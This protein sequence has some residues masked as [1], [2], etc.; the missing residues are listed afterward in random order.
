[1]LHTGEVEIKMPPKLP[2][3]EKTPLLLNV[4]PSFSMILPI[5]LMTLLGSSLYG[6]NTSFMYASLISGGTGC[7]LGGI[8]ALSNRL[9]QNH[10]CERRIAHMKEE[11]QRYLADRREYLMVC[12]QDNRR[13]LETLYPNA[14]TILHGDSVPLVQRHEADDDFAFA[15]LGTGEIP[16]QM[17]IKLEG[18]QEGLFENE[19]EIAAKALAEEYRMISDCPVGIDFRKTHHVAINMPKHLESTYEYILNILCQ[20]ALHVSAGAMKICIFADKQNEYQRRLTEIVK[21]VPHL[22]LNGTGRRLLGID[23]DSA[24]RT[25]VELSR[26]IEKDDVFW[27]VLVLDDGYLKDETTYQTIM[28]ENFDN[29]SV[30]LLADKDATPPIF[31]ENIEFGKY[32]GAESVSFRNAEKLL[33]DSVRSFDVV[34]GDGGYIPDKVGYLEMYGISRI[35]EIKLL[36]NWRRNSMSDRIRV[37]IGIRE[38]NMIVY[39]DISEK[40]H[41][42]HGLLAGTTGSGKSELI[43]TYVIG[44]C[45]NYSPTS[46]NFLLIDYKGGGT[47]NVI[48]AL[49]HCAGVI[50]NLSGNM[51]LRAIHAISSEVK[52][53][54]MILASHGLAHVDEYRKLEPNMQTDGPMP[55]LILIID[56][57]AELK[58]EEPEFMREI[59]SLAA[60]GRSLGIHLIL[61]TQKPAGV[62]DDKIWSNSHFKLCLKVQDKQDSM[63]MLHRGEAALLSKA[64]QCYLQ[65]GNNEYFGKFQTA[66]CKDIYIPGSTSKGVFMMDACANK[67]SCK[68][69]SDTQQGDSRTVLEE[70]ADY[71][72]QK[73]PN[74]TLKARQLWMDEMDIDV[75]LCKLARTSAIHPPILGLYDDPKNQRQGIL[76][77]EYERRGHMIIV[78]M[79]KSG[80]TNLLRVLLCQKTISDDAVYIDVDSRD[81]NSFIQ[82]V[83]VGS[84]LKPEDTEIFMHHLK[85]LCHKRAGENAQN[86]LLV[87]I[88]NFR[89]FFKLLKDEDAEFMVNLFSIGQSRNIYVIASG[90]M[91]SDFPPRIFAKAGYTI[92]M[93]MND[94]YAYRDIMRNPTDVWPK[95]HTPGRCLAYVDDQILECQIAK[96]DTESQENMCRVPNFVFPKIP[97][98]TDIQK[99]LNTPEI[100]EYIGKG[101]LPL[102]YSQKTGKI[103]GFEPD[104]VGK[105]LIVDDLGKM[106]RV[107]KEVIE[108]VVKNNP[109][110]FN[111]DIMLTKTTLVSNA[112]IPWGEELTTPKEQKEGI[113]VQGAAMNSHI[114]DFGELSYKEMSSPVKKGSGWLKICGKK[115]VCIKL[116]NMGG[117]VDE[118][119][120]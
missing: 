93:E 35:E 55:H 58:K 62:V 57:F 54:E 52:R 73:M 8:W 23:S 96:A 24:A 95:M 107:I 80:K 17:K 11:Y 27:L 67:T 84:I 56:E 116:L 41:G 90:G 59:I 20:L 82:G 98:D 68:H 47:A 109:E 10:D 37:P 51:I 102:G 108:F 33:F 87:F 18:K 2:E 76:K 88:D 119:D 92:A 86:R 40:Y 81:S 48:D 38:N 12:A 105:F 77:Y 85:R 106:G 63:D 30:V 99:L 114:L 113:L 4:G 31:K 26:H 83:T 42:P 97:D 91:V 74:E 120:E 111:D 60:V 66:Y 89:S 44:L 72:N 29:L 5:L 100:A 14:E 50:S 69:M 36:D 49:P 78:G 7:L 117:E 1:M 70:L 75:D 32:P 43:Q 28:S 65:V 71:V 104:K 101:M 9:Y 64:G 53:R 103:C 115:P 110:R 25:L 34:Q 3:R 16:F 19:A 21:F 118:D 22:F 15:R 46:V 61:A 13:Y 79:P 6:G 39:L 94:K 112:D 45:L